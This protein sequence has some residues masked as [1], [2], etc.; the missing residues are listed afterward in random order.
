MQTCMICLENC[1]TIIRDECK[2]KMICHLECFEKWYLTSPCCFICMKSS[3]K[4][5]NRDCYCSRINYAI[6]QFCIKWFDQCYNIVYSSNKR[7]EL[8][9]RLI[10][11]LITTTL[12]LCVFISP[13]LFVNEVSW[14]IE[15][16]IRDLF[17]SN[18]PS[19]HIE[20]IR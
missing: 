8:Y 9:S 7:L 18:Q 20:K 2:C 3:L 13:I 10:V 1:D 14:T 6:I 19:L 12:F 5:P 17:I 15:K 16:I 4:I 11:C